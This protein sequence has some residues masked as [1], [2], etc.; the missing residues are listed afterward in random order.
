MSS[1]FGLLHC[2]TADYSHSRSQTRQGSTQ[3]A[4]MYS[5]TMIF[6]YIKAEVTNGTYLCQ[7]FPSSTEVLAAFKTALCKSSHS[8][9]LYLT[10]SLETSQYPFKEHIRNMAKC[11]TAHSPV[12]FHDVWF[13]FLFQRRI[14]SVL[15]MLEQQTSQELA[16]EVPKGPSPRKL[17]LK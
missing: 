17:N 10:R 15:L 1:A 3:R 4:E 14:F 11:C 7:N 12:K 5:S 13:F 8:D 9:I 6:P 2:T 16:A